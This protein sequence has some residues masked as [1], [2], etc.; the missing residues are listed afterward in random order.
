MIQSFQKKNP[1]HTKTSP[2]RVTKAPKGAVFS[3]TTKDSISS[4]VFIVIEYAAIV[5]IVQEKKDLTDAALLKMS[6]RKNGP[7]QNDFV[8]DN[9]WNA[10]AYAKKLADL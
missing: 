5:R 10:L 2:I 1:S 9:Y 4:N 3:S 8:F 7:Y 6:D